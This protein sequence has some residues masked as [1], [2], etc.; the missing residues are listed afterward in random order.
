ME[1]ITPD[2]RVYTLETQSSQD[3]SNAFK[4][5][6][7]INKKPDSKKQVTKTNSSLTSDAVVEKMINLSK[8]TSNNLGDIVD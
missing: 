1:P 6:V 4:N 3:L 8:S 2:P 7:I 5:A